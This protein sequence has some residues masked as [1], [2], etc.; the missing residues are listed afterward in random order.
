MTNTE[1][2]QE[3]IDTITINLK[4]QEKQFAAVQGGI[5][6]TKQHINNL[7]AKQKSLEE[8][9]KTQEKTKIKDK[10]KK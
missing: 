3:L 9:I 7:I 2:L 10:K 4:E 5:I 8:Q 1:L 6:M